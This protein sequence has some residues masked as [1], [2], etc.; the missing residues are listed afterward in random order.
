M[1]RRMDAWA[2]GLFNVQWGIGPC[3]SRGFHHPTIARATPPT[4]VTL[5]AVRNYA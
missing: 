1:D 2:D 4:L 3:P 5:I